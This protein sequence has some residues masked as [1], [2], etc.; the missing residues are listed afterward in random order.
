MGILKHITRNSLAAH[1]FA[2]CIETNQPYRLMDIKVFLTHRCNLR[3]IMCTSWTETWDERDELSTDELIRIIAQAKPLGLA[4]LKLFGGEPTL[5]RDLEDIIKHAAG[6]DIRCT[7]V[8]NGT[9][10]EKRAPLLVEAGLSE[11]DLSL[12]ASSPELHD[13]I[14]GVPGTWQRTM[15]GLELM[16]QA[17]A[18]LN[19]PLVIRVNTVV[20]RQNY[21]DMPRLVQMLAA[22]GVDEITL[23]PVIPQMDNRRAQ[24]A[25]YTLLPEDIRRYNDEVAPRIAEYAAGY[26]LSAETDRL[27]IYGTSEA[28]IA[29]AAQCR[30]VERLQIQRCFKPW[31]Y[32]VIRENGDIVG[33]NT[34]KRSA[35]LMGNVRE[36]TIEEIWFSEAYLTFRANCK[37]PQL[38]GCENCCYHF[39]LLNKQMEQTLV[40]LMPSAPLASP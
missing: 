36:A 11:I 21:H 6:L 17:A 37:P 20:M 26:R 32:M 29:K 22:C 35:G 24:S 13:K 5:R 12:D 18:A 8:T 10:I 38:E 31:Y 7:L 3:C 16:R 33:C 2:Q 40:H 25:E 34:V 30:Y 14:R 19:R 4:N 23:N 15:R 39:A 1:T 9:L 28:D 27:Y